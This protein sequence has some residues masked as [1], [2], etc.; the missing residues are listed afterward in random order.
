MR[1]RTVW[2]I[3][4]VLLLVGACQQ[5]LATPSPGHTNALL[6]TASAAATATSAATATNTA[7]APPK[8]DPV[9]GLPFAD[10]ADLPPEAATTLD[11]IA[12]GGPFPH[13]QD[14]VV[15]Q[16]REGLLPD[17]PY[18]YYHEYTVDTPG[19]SDRGARRIITGVG[20]EFYYTADHYASFERIRQ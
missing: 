6:P 13:S 14:G 16:N 12:T 20:G 18:G 7:T 4:S 5:P 9:S 2:W 3:A 10:L 1:A 11:L 17:Q 8:I 19:S 15:F